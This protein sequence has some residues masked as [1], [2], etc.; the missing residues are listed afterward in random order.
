MSGKEEFFFVGLRVPDDSPAFFG[1]AAFFPFISFLA[2]VGF[3]AMGDKPLLR[4]SR[5]RFMILAGVTGVSCK[6][7]RGDIG[8]LLLSDDDGIWFEGGAGGGIE[9]STGEGVSPSATVLFF[10]ERVDRMSGVEVVDLE[11]RVDF[12]MIG[13]GFDARIAGDCRLRAGFDES[14]SPLRDAVRFCE[15]RDCAVY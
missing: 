8:M 14:S 5:P 4:P 1:L 11:A 6:S 9:R 7:G 3:C 13:A 15:T 2:D 10:R 12:F